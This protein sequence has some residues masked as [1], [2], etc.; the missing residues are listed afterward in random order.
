[1]TLPVLSFSQILGLSGLIV[2]API[3]WRH[4]RDVADALK[5]EQS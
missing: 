3:V 1:M 4:W 2:T 5:E